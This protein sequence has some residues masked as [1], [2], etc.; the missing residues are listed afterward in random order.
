M[1]TSPFEMYMGQLLPIEDYRA[2]GC[3]CNTHTKI[4]V[5]CDSFG[6]KSSNIWEI[7]STVMDSNMKEAIGTIQAAFVSAMQNPFQPVGCPIV[8]KKFDSVIQQIVQRF[9]TIILTAHKRRN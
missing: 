9:N 8:S 2:Y 3:Y 6:M 1:S 4:I 5:L 7:S